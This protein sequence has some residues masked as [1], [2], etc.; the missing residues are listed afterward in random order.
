[1]Q[2]EWCYRLLFKDDVFQSTANSS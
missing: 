2:N 1:M